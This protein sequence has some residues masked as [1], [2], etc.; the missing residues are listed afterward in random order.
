MNNPF[1]SLVEPQKINEIVENTLL[2]TLNP[3]KSNLYYVSN[4]ESKFFTLE[5][6]EFVLFERII[7]FDIETDNDKKVILYLYNCFQRV[8]EEVKKYGSSNELINVL[9]KIEQL[10]FQNISTILKEPELIPNQNLSSQF[11]DIYKYDQDIDNERDRFLSMSI[12]TAL[13][14]CDSDMKKNV[15]EIF[16]KC[17][18]TC[19]RIVKISS[20]I[21]LEKWVLSFLMAFSSDKNNPAMANMFIDYI[22]PPENSEGIKYSETLL[23]QLLSLSIC[24]KNNLGPFEYYGDLNNTNLTALNNLSSSLWNYLKIIHDSLGILVKSLLVVGGETRDKMLKWLGNA[25]SSNQKRGQIWNAHSSMILGNFT[26]APDST[27]IGLSAVLLRLCLPLMKPQLK[28]M[29]VD[30]TFT[31]VKNEDIV[32]KQIH[33]KDY[34]KE[35]NLIP[36]DEDEQRVTAEKYNFITEI[37]FLTHKCIDLSY[38]VC[39]EKVSRMNREIHRL[40]Q[41]YQDATRGGGTSDVTENIM[42]MLTK[43]SQILL[44]TQ[45]LILEP[46]NDEL[47]LKFYE[48]TAIWLNQL[49]IKATIDTKD[50][51][52]GFAPIER[53][54][55]NLP[56]TN[57]VSPFLKYVPELII[58][59]IVGYLQF[60]KHFDTYIKQNHEAKEVFLT[61]CLIFMGNSKRVK[62]PHLR[63]HLSEGLESLL[64]R[65][66]SNGFTIDTQLFYQH[67]HRRFIVENLLDVF[68]S[69]EMT[70]QSVQFEQKFNYRRPMYAIMKYL[71]DID[72]QRECF[73]KMSLFA[74]EHIDDVEVPL[75]LRF[76]NVL[77]NDSIFLLD[78]SLNN[79]QKIREMEEA[80]S[81]GDWDK[82]PQNERQQN[83]QNLMQ[84]GMLAKFDNILGKDTIH[85]LKLLTSETKEIFIHPTMVERITN[86]LN[87]FLLQLCGPNQKRFKVQNKQEYD[88]NPA[89]TVKEICQIY[90]NLKDCDEFC[91]AVTQDGRSYSSDLFKYAENTL[92]KI[93]GGQLITDITE[94]AE[95]VRQVEQR[96]KENEEALVNPPDNFL[97]PILSI[98]MRDPVILPS[99]RVTCDKSTISRHLLSDQSDPFNRSPLSMDQLIPDTKLKAQIDA[100]IKERLEKYKNENE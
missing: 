95:K 61:T 51:E 88:F 83:H 5:L 93:G 34:E 78:E 57:D 94:F 28:V 47:L 1:A 91:L 80:K 36:F 62:N 8:Q 56:L 90:L 15:T 100:W 89:H 48:A 55:I 54:K 37:F 63:A 65:E 74:Q 14:D 84:L 96:Q 86:M 22:T 92:I 45:N 6:L 11:L 27:M 52:K 72:E 35:T 41:A 25:I 53:T 23:G 29:L 85:I 13:S 20:M 97:D 79:L 44:C 24:P 7:A 19:T 82:L 33:I 12:L 10:I 46:K 17:F 16:N 76:I 2:L 81:K 43:Q 18:D 50:F 32:K 67:E 98:L 9:R 39:I 75:Y 38:R 77:I 21:T 64:P 31:V 42:N 4:D 70:G 30:P 71:W 49:T 68:V 3:E 59:N 40:Q 66:N 58:E 73:R 69:I 99:S 26:T 60:S 87:Y